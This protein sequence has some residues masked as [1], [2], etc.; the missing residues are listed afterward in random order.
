MSGG[1]HGDYWWFN[2]VPP[3]G[4]LGSLLEFCWLLAPDRHLC[5]AYQARA[6]SSPGGSF[7]RSQG[8]GNL[9]LQCCGWRAPL[10]FFLSFHLTSPAVFLVESISIFSHPTSDWWEMRLFF[11]CPRIFA[12]YPSPG[13]YIPWPSS[14]TSYINPSWVVPQFCPFRFQLHVLFS[15]PGHHVC[16]QM[17]KT[18]LGIFPVAT[19]PTF[20]PSLLVLPN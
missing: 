10:H 14:L 4:N 1:H 6:S 15:P 9:V 16:R 8:W 5:E 17:W 13:T 11:S 7:P 18:L 20:S 12:L 19:W 2:T 3:H